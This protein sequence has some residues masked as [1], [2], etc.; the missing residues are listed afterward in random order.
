MYN[1]N[2]AD[3][4][5]TSRHPGY[6]ESDLEEQVIFI[7][8]S[9]S[10]EG[11]DVGWCLDN[12]FEQ[13]K[14]GVWSGEWY[15]R[16]YGGSMED[17]K[18]AR[19]RQQQRNNQSREAK[20]RRMREVL[21]TIGAMGGGREFDESSWAGDSDED[22]DG[23]DSFAGVE[24]TPAMLAYLAERK[25]EKSEAMK[26]YGEREISNSCQACACCGITANEL[27]SSLCRCSRC[28]LIKYCGRECQKKDWK[29]HKRRCTDSS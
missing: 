25:Q 3:D 10:D 1:D 14:S 7:R 24:P 22:S 11:K 13:V 21:A 29:T 2:D 26:S 8:P 19:T 17:A 4:R 15:W 20:S 12:G 5:R 9:F 27:G 28:K 6:S 18:T 16:K 23:E